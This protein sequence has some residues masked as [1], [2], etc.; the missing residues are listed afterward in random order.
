V[1]ALQKNSRQSYWITLKPVMEQRR[2]RL[3]PA[4]D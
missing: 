4:T 1:S 3:D 2:P